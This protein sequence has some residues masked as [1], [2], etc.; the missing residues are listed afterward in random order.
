[1]RGIGELMSEKSVRALEDERDER[2][3]ATGGHDF[4]TGKPCHCE[5]C[6]RLREE[7]SVLAAMIRQ[8]RDA[9]ARHR[10]AGRR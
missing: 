2:E 6:N 8:R 4:V 1:M 9:E 3:Q 10:A 5:R 7:T